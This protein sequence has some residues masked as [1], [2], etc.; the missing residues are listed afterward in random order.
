[1][2][3]IHYLVISGIIGGVIGSLLT[4]LLVSPVTA[5]RDK[6][7]EIE[8][9]GL[10]VVDKGGKTVVM[11]RVD[12]QGGRVSIIGKDGNPAWI[13]GVGEHAGYVH[14][15]SNSGNVVVS[16]TGDERGGYVKAHGKDGKLR[17]LL[18]GGEHGGAVIATGDGGFAGMAITEHGGRVEFNGKGEGS[19]F[20]G[21]NEYGNGT[22]ATWDKNG[23]RQD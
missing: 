19:A 22:V 16:L 3:T 23:Y 2:K 8:C 4:A 18:G 11:M 12:D 5:Q 9:T 10:R 14:T 15:Y 7:G 13:N 17:V 21:I 6:F 1:M 20:M